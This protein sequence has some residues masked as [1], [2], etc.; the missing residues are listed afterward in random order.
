MF[1]YVVCRFIK[2]NYSLGS[3]AYVYEVDNF[4]EIEIGNR[5]KIERSDFD[6]DDPSIEVTGL[7]S[8]DREMKVC[9]TH[10]IPASLLLEK[11]IL[12]KKLK[13]INKVQDALFK[14]SGIKPNPELDCEY[15]LIFQGKK[16][17]FLS[18]ILD[19]YPTMSLIGVTLSDNRENISYDKIVAKLEIDKKFNTEKKGENLMK[20]LFKGAEFGKCNDRRIRMSL[21]GISY[22]TKDNRYVVYDEKKETFTDVTPFIID[23]EN[24]CYL[25]PVLTK[26]VEI[27]DVI[28]HNDNYFIVAHWSNNYIEAI[29]PCSNE[30]KNILPVQNMFGFNFYT[31]VISL[32]S[33]DFFDS[34]DENNP[35]GNMLPYLLFSEENQ[36]SG[37]NSAIKAYFMMNMMKNGEINFQD[38]PYLMMMLLDNKNDDSGLLPLMFMNKG[39]FN[40]NKKTCNCKNC[41]EKS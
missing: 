11:G 1:Y 5:Y 16:Y 25:V 26:D 24:Y 40:T 22:L 21:Y 28:K 33:K 38:N 30:V 27:G 9:G 14:C 12:I 15:P 35:F 41:E 18:E 39:I 17:H 4:S 36:S 37:S 3:K 7:Y 2:T 10:L 32:V 19:D 29:D 13:I 6:F 31:K 20:N 8:T 23:T 34:A